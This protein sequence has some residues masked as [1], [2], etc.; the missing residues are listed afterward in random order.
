MLSEMYDS[1]INVEICSSVK[2]IQYVIKY[3]NKGS[4]MAAFALQRRNPRD[5]IDVFQ[6]ARYVSCSKAC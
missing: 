2:A 4:D 1:H 5:E 3:V 6:A